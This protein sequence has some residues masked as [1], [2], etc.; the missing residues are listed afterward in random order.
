MS[1]RIGGV[2]QILNPQNFLSFGK[3]FISHQHISRFFVNFIM[4][5]LFLFHGCRHIRRPQIL[6]AGAF[7]LTRNNQRRAGL[8]NQH[9]VNFINDAEVERALYHIFH[10]RRHIIA[11]VVK[12][13]FAVSGI[14]N[15]AGVIFLAFRRFHSLLNQSHS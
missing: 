5:F 15:I 1:P 7:H 6:L 11:Q 12:T 10:R 3:A 4:L 2:V 9:R 13:Y 8:I 14:S